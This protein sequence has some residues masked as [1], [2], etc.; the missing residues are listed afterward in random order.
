MDVGSNKRGCQKRFD[1][2]DPNATLANPVR[3]ASRA[4]ERIAGNERDGHKDMRCGNGWR[5]RVSAQGKKQG[6][7]E[8]TRRCPANGR[9]DAGVPCEVMLGCDWYKSCPTLFA[10]C[11]R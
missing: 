11:A 6:C 1:Y 7:P 8:K 2:Y 10:A 3:S 9:R 4:G 5:R